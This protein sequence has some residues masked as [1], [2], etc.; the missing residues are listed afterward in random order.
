MENVEV[1]DIGAH[2]ERVSFLLLQLLV[3]GMDDVSLSCCNS[4]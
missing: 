1:N 3:K 4:W 2:G